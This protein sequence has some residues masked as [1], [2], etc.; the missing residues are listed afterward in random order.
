MHSDLPPNIKSGESARLIP[1]VAE[2][3]REKRLASTFLAS[4]VAVPDLAA[5]LLA[6]ISQRVGKRTRLQAFTEIVFS[7]QTKSLQDRPDGLLVLHTGR[8]SWSALIEA[9]IGRNELTAEQISKY[10]Q[11][12]KDNDIDAVITI[13]NQFVARPEHSPIRISK[14]S[15]KSVNLYH[16]SWMFILTQANFLL[17][18]ND[19]YENS[20]YYILNEIYR[21]FSHSSAG[22]DSFDRMNKEW[23]EIVKTVQSG[24][25]LRPSL[26]E[27]EKTVA[28]WH[29]ETRDLCLLMSRHL[30]RD[31]TLKL[32]REHKT[33]PNKRLSNDC[34]FLTE[35][36]A[37]GCVL[38]IPDTASDLE[39]SADLQT[40]NL[41][42]TVRLDAP[43]DRKQTK[44]RVNWLL[45]QLTKIKD[46][47]IYIRAIWPS[48]AVDTMAPLDRVRDDPRVL[49]SDNSKLA[50]RAFD[51]VM[52]KDLAGKFS[53][54]KTFIQEVEANVLHFY[55]EVMQHLRAW[56]PSP[57]KPRT[58]KDETA[59]Y[60]EMEAGESVER[61]DEPLATDS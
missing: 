48:R 25:V 29:Q 31:V 35:R 49:Q 34:K 32:K 37:L 57:P 8:R 44:S 9:K 43:Q 36:K 2:T 19:I 11:I 47:D 16:W 52:S 61:Q 59:R 20:D 13:S 40:R 45:R 55:N 33:S 38:Q 3:S 46:K 15:L 50:P 18:D 27:V 12:A 22:I 30:A 56:Q 26:A 58:A 4:L 39:I 54:S 53:G 1:V 23:R 41:V 51:V 60:A 42:C 24:G 17:T 14:N 6:S 5:T 7:N 10:L 21:F 28:C